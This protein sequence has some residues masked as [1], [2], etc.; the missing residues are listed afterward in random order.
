MDIQQIRIGKHQIG[1]IGLESAIKDIA[2]EFRER[3]D[4]EIR[5][6]LLRRLSK[7]NYINKMPPEL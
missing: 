2:D 4:E 5:S 3:T 1:I 6:E 7:R